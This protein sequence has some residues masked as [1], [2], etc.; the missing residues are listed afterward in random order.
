[1]GKSL[2]AL[3][4]VVEATA[5]QQSFVPY[6]NSRLTML[7]QEALSASKILLLAHVSPFARDST[8][9]AQSLQFAS[10]LRAT[11]FSA[12]RLRQDQE[13]RAKAAQTR[14]QQEITQLQTQLEQAK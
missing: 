7:L 12:Q 3:A 1:M 13:D 5:K 8:H 14:F 10:R 9:T 6:R 11:D 4:D 2:S